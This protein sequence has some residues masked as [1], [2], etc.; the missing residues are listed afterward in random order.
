MTMLANLATK[1]I[2]TVGVLLLY[3]DASD[4]KSYSMKLEVQQCT[5][6]SM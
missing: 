5:V 3:L 4:D 2:V 6:L 1:L